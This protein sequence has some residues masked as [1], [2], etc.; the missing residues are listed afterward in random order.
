LKS[1]TAAH[2][3]TALLQDAKQRRQ[4]L[5]EA[6]QMLQLQQLDTASSVRNLRGLERHF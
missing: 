3:K 2:Y 1:Q 6:F 4:N 5:E